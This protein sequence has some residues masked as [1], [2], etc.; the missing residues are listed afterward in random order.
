MFLFYLKYAI[1]KMHFKKREKKHVSCMF[2]IRHWKKTLLNND[3]AD[4][5]AGYKYDGVYRCI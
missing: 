3:T 5:P 1:L 2:W 4:R